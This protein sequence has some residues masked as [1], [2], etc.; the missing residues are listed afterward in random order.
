ME[1]AAD[2]VAC[3]ASAMDHLVMTPAAAEVPRPA[4]AA[5]LLIVDVTLGKPARLEIGSD[6][7][8]QVAHG[9]GR[10]VDETV[11]GRE[12]PVGGDAEVASAGSAGIGAMS[13][14]MELF[15]RGDEV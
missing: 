2:V 6:A 5:R 10:I 7:L 13:A 9:V 1:P 11:A 15:E 4:V 8:L 14:A 12:L 3:R